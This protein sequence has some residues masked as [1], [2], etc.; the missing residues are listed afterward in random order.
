ML[1][2]TLNL[3]H[4]RAIGPQLLDA[5]GHYLPATML[6]FNT[7]GDVVS[8]DPNALIAPAAG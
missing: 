1:L 4:L 2:E 3:V 6:A 5:P 7:D 8:T